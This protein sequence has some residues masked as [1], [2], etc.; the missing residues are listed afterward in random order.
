MSFADV[1]FCWLVVLNSSCG[2][3]ERPLNELLILQIDS[4]SC[5]AFGSTYKE[6]TKILLTKA[7]SNMVH[8]NQLYAYFN[9]H[10]QIY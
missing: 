7:E 9:S 2:E 6:E 5:R 10:D 1:I 4:Q 3:D 8:T